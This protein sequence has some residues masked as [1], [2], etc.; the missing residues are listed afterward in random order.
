VADLWTS[1]P[2]FPGGP[3][4]QA[5]AFAVET[6]GYIGSG[7]RD[8][9]TP[10]KDF[11]CYDPIYGWKQI[12][13]LPGPGLVSCSSFVMNGKGYVGLGTNLVGNFKD[14][15]SYKPA[16]NTWNAVDP[17]PSYFQARTGAVSFSI[18]NIG[19]IATGYTNT[20]LLADLWSICEPP[21]CDFSFHLNNLSVSFTDQ[22]DNADS[23][24][25]DFGDGTT[26]T[27]QNP[28]HSFDADGTYNVCLT[29]SNSCN[30]EKY[31][32]S[33]TVKLNGIDEINKHDIL[34]YPDPVNDKLYVRWGMI[35][36]R[37]GKMFV[38]NSVGSVIYEQEIVKDQGASPEELNLRDLNPG[39]YDLIIITDDH[40]IVKKFIVDHSSKQ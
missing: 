12:A 22:S 9:Y 8:S 23:W 37:S 1:K 20:E 3:R 18:S 33:I 29:A 32:A 11:W 5:V 39:M 14:F 10:T 40:V 13:D 7:S 19:Y 6:K 38:V 2:D 25:W 4:N 35:S 36:H 26:S 15:W 28:V 27:F 21:H 34:L 24:Y 17:P 31:C 16:L 30:N